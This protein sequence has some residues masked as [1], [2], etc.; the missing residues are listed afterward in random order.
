MRAN[1]LV[2]NTTYVYFALKLE[3]P[4]CDR[5]I[6]INV[7]EFMLAW[8][9][10][11]SSVYKTL[12]KLENLNALKLLNKKL[13]IQWAEDL[14]LFNTEIEN[15]QN[16]ENSQK[17]EN[18][19]KVENKFSEVR[20]NSQKR[21]NHP[22]EPLPDKDFDSL[23]TLQNN[24][25]TTDS[26]EELVVALEFC[27]ETQEVLPS[28]IA[29]NAPTQEA[30]LEFCEET[31]EIKSVAPTKNPQELPRQNELKQMGVRIND[32]EL[33]KAVAAYQ[34][35]IIT[36]IRAFLEYAMKKEVKNPTKAF[37]SAIRQN[38]EPDKNYED[39]GL[40]KE[41]NAP[42]PEQIAKLQE[43]KSQGMIADFYFSDD[44]VTK[45]V[46]FREILIGKQM[47]KVP[48]PTKCLPWWEVLA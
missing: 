40:P 14:E 21:E 46:P 32:S 11:E 48:D 22:L 9:V 35:Q 42:T 3:N 10:P 5:P 2:N 36:P 27:E 20:V 16:G 47:R 25:D 34:G 7:K 13:V 44:G 8:G 41:E 1:K 45:V 26:K 18:I 29:F 15:S 43:L 24:S 30:A 23:Q 19:L 39:G 4:F 12:A 33:Q 6:E 37:T 17:R 38:W 28:A 31:Q